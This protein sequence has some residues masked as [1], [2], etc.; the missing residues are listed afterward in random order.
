MFLAKPGL[1]V[2]YWYGT[3]M[4]LWLCRHRTGKLWKKDN[5]RYQ[6]KWCIWVLVSVV[7]GFR[8]HKK[9]HTLSEWSE[10]SLSVLV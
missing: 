2:C 7:V 3:G 4:V 8:L 5:R 10:K 9:V 1:V 6:W